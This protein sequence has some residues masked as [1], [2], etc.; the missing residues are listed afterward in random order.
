MEPEQGYP[1]SSTLS[2][3]NDQFIFLGKNGPTTNPPTMNVIVVHVEKQVSATSSIRAYSLSVISLN[4]VTALDIIF[5]FPS[6]DFVSC[7]NKLSLPPIMSTV[8][9][10]A[11]LEACEKVGNGPDM[12]W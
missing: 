11:T 5:P 7:F 10:N 8:L 2:K 12:E 1:N 4:F 3:S 9:N 6:M